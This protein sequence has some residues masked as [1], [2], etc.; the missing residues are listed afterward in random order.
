MTRSKTPATDEYVSGLVG[1]LDAY[2]KRHGRQVGDT[3]V[4]M[5]DSSISRNFFGW[6]D[7]ASRLRQGKIT[8]QKARQFEEKAIEG[9]I[10]NP[11]PKP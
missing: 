10:G 4:P 3:W 11:R 2:A 8:L 1:L 6:Q 7:F 9:I 5:S